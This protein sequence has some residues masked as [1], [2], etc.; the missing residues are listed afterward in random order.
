[1]FIVGICNQ[2]H[3]YV[4]AFLPKHKCRFAIC[5]DCKTK[6]EVRQQDQQGA[7]KRTRNSLQNSSKRARNALDLNNAL[8]KIMIIETLRQLM[9]FRFS[10]MHFLNKSKKQIVH[11]QPNASSAMLSFLKTKVSWKVQDRKVNFDNVTITFDAFN[12]FK[13]LHIIGT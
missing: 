5:E 7:T 6:H 3:H 4:H 12:K 10:T 2:V 13:Y 8:N 9:M 1:M 11:F